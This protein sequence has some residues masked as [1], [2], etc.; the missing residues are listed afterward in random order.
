M[1]TSPRFFA[2]GPS[3]L[4]RFF[5][6]ALLSV[7]LMIADKHTDQ[8]SELR[9]VIGLA[10]S[11]LQKSAYAP[12]QFYHQLGQYLASFDLIEEI[13][14][15]KQEHL[16]NQ[17]E[18]YQL[19]TLAN[20][21]RH[22][23]ALLGATEQSQFRTVLAEIMSTPRNPFNRKIVLNKGSSSGIREGHI[24]IDNLGVIGQVTRIYPLTAE[25]TLITDKGHTVPVKIARNAINTV[26]SGAGRNHELELQFLSVNT[27]VQPGDLLVTSGIGG[28]YPPG[29]PVGRVTHIEHDKSMQ[30][31]RIICTPVAGVDRHR[32]VLVLI[33]L[34]PETT[35]SAEKTDL[36]DSHANQANQQ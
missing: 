30:F 23:R 28:V 27:D 24:V 10:V 36:T 19:R 2:S 26:I 6:Y 5:L 12:F 11:P 15:L 17:H 29:L 16:R 18:L 22:L 33:D 20:E 35:P 25:V 13:E 31:S 34:P 21:N 1:Y 3:P 7:L 4:T 14:Q 8:F 32:H 9:R